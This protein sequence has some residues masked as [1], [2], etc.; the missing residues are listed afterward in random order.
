MFSILNKEDCKNLEQMTSK[1][2][3]FSLNGYKTFAKCVHAY[4]GDTIHVVFKMPH[5]NEY[6]KW[7]IRMMGIDTPEIKSKNTNEKQLAVKARDFLRELMLDKIIIIEC[8]DFDKYGRL[9]GNLFIEGSDISISNMM[10]EKGY[11]KAYDGGT[12]TTWE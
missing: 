11:A 9:L 6:N 12:K 1:T 8:L 4:D 5:S 3:K 10:I 7:V 2:N